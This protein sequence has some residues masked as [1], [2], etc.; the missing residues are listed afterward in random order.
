MEKKGSFFGSLLLFVLI[1]LIIFVSYEIYQNAPGELVNF[2]IVLPE[3]NASL[4]NATETL[5]MFYP[6]M[7]FV[8]NDLSFGFAGECTPDKKERIYEAFEIISRETQILSFKE[9]LTNPIIII[10]CSEI[11]KETTENT[12]IAGEGGPEKVL[13]STLYPL[14]GGGRVYLYGTK[15]ES[16]C[17]YPV[18]EIHELM[19]VFGFNHITNKSSILYPYLDCEQ[20]LDAEIISE[21]IRLYS[22]EPK[23]ELKIKNANVSKSGV[24]LN[25][26]IEI[27]N[28]GLIDANNNFLQIK[29]S[30]NSL[31]KDFELDDIEPGTT[32]TLKVQ[33]LK[34]PSRNTNEVILEIITSTR[35]FYSENNVLIAKLS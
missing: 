32:Q 35:E 17:E 3:D 22:I 23:A 15:K 28:I 21:L 1:L 8:S 31:I 6:N 24:Y 18:V 33:N 9:S 4:E 5:E 16:K 13:N 2:K 26:N 11:E 25:F 12:Y 30:D 34:L 10:F 29:T 27:E 7:R 19:H 14:I 20:K